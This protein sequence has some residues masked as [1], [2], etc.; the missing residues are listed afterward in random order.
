MAYTVARLIS[1]AWNLSGIVARNLQGVQG[2]QSGDGLFLLNELLEFKAIDTKL[3]PYFRHS[4]LTLN[5]NQEMYFIPNL[6]YMESMTFNIGSVRYSMEPAL[7]QQ[8]WG[9]DR[10]LDILSLP[11]QYHFERVN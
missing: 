8:Y 1:R 7:R 6:V 11:F 4:S 9:D 2:N 3:I 10:A 5:A